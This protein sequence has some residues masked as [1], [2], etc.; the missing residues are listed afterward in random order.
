[1]PI[2]AV[3]GHK[4]T[5]T[6]NRENTAWLLLNR[7]NNYPGSVMTAA[8]DFNE[9]DFDNDF[10]HSDDEFELWTDTDGEYLND[11]FGPNEKEE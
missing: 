1:M 7:R 3:S 8:W 4:I 6:R 5:N 11:A 10:N 9:Y 2:G